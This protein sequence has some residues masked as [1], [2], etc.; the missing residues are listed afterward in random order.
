[1][2]GSVRFLDTFQQEG[3]AVLAAE[4]RLVAPQILSVAQGW[5]RP[6]QPRQLPSPPPWEHPQAKARDRR[7]I[8]QTHSWI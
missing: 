7:R 8:I 1:M 4:A 2:K 5:L 3:M 6:S